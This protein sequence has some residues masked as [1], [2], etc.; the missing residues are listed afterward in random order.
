MLT[1]SPNSLRLVDSLS[2]DILKLLFSDSDGEFNV[3]I[4]VGE[5]P[6]RIFHAHSLILKARSTYFR[7]ALMK[8]ELVNSKYLLRKNDIAPEVFEPIL[9]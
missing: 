8:T 1:D 6:E 4:L 3:S 9:R 2:Q 5:F 7:D